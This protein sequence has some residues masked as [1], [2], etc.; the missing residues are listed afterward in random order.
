MMA[1]IDG[2]IT[3][4]RLY[5]DQESFQQNA[6]IIIGSDDC[7]VYL[8]MIKGYPKNLEV[9]D[10]GNSESTFLTRDK[11]IDNFIMDAPNA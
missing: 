11:H 4:A 2:V 3:T 8:Y 1:W 10:N 5:D 9:E 6:D 7:D